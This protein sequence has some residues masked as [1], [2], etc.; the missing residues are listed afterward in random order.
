MH[1]PA[2][3]RIARRPDDHI[4][5]LHQRYVWGCRLQDLMQI[6]LHPA[7]AEIDDQPDAAQLGHI[8]GVAQGL[9]ERDIGNL[10]IG[11]F[12]V[13]NYMRVIMASLG[14]PRQMGNFIP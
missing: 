9:D 6:P 4:A 5:D 7:V 3:A 1:A 2:G 11:A 12:L 10:D 8:H 14:H 13:D